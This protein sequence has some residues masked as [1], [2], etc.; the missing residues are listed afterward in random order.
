MLV[1]AGAALYTDA[2][3]RVD[4][5]IYDVAVRSFA[6]PPQDDVV[7]V[8]IDERSLQYLGRWPW[9]RQTHARLVD[10]ATRYGAQ[11]IALDI[12]FAEPETPDRA[13]DLELAGA[14]AASGRVVLPVAP[15]RLSEGGP[16]GE[17][18]P[19]PS[20]SSAAARLGHVDTPLDLD[21]VARGTFLHAGLGAPVWPSFALATAQTGDGG[22][23]NLPG[24]PRARNITVNS[25]TWVGERYI[26]VPFSGPTGTYRTLSYVDVLDDDG[27]AALL[28][29]KF[30][31]V[32]PTAIGLAPALATPLSGKSQPMSGV[33]FE[34]NVLGALLGKTWIERIDA[35]P[36]LLGVIALAF[37]PLFAYRKLEPPAALLVCTLALASIFFLSLALVRL[38]IWIAPAPALA[39]LALG[40]LLWSWRRL[41]ATRRAILLQ[42]ESDRA[43]LNSVGDAVIR[44]D[45]DGRIR[46]MNPVAERL[47]GVALEGARER[48]FREV[49][50]PAGPVDL[51]QVN[52]IL[53]RR[54]ARD[55]SERRSTQFALR[56]RTSVTRSVQLTVTHVSDARGRADGMVLALTDV[57][58][59]VQLT[60]KLSHL[61]MHDHLT[62]LPNRLLLIDRVNL[63]IT[64]ASRN[65][66][67]LAV[68]FVDLDGFKRINDSLGHSGGDEVLKQMAQRLLAVGRSGDTIARWGGDEFVIVM[69]DLEREEIIVGIARK[70]LARIAEPFFYQEEEVF[71]TASIGIA[72][73]PRDATDG[74]TLLKN[75]DATMYRVKRQAPNGFRFYSEE[76]NHSTREHLA[77][78]NAMRYAVKR[79]E[80][81]L[82]YQPQIDLSS[83]RVTGAESLIRWRNPKRGLLHPASFLSIAEE[84]GLIDEIGLWAMTEACVQARTWSEQGLSINVAINVSP[85]QILRTGMVS[86]VENVL[87]ESRVDPARITLEIIETAVLHDIER[88][89]VILGDLKTLGIHISIDDFGTG[90][91]SLTHIKRFP[92]DE[93]KID[94]SFVRGITTD[95]NDAAITQAV[96]SMAHGMGIKVIAEGVE[97]EGQLAFLRDRHCDEWQGFLFAHPLPARDFAARLAGHRP[98]LREVGQTRH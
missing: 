90:F 10:R 24:E 1:V 42:L 74:E 37:L 84:C 51:M 22:D 78:E 68:L 5:L 17:V 16:L 60:Q 28:R 19:I 67:L 49:F 33:E 56:D 50:E 3:G 61:A 86:T 89:Q 34:A 70:I 53:R 48:D 30:V 93:V 62:S 63:A 66:Q 69:D 58:P 39:A 12:L 26:L 73:Y 92:I 21:G 98:V 25:G 9:S 94:Q 76:M 32:G 72:L 11:S 13:A 87:R 4:N 77:L 45:A 14:L 20:L 40:Y 6:P 64:H 15:A 96:I 88:L 44:T 65:N 54:R 75:A 36:R 85:R 47:S 91:S 81:D 18:Q 52:R 8:A 29:H 71:L 7:I 27:T 57:T 38:G 23:A 2:L 46:Y 31:L 41:G 79:H 82:Y 95:P 80:F 59:M 97:T 43:T 35:T 55:D 83:G